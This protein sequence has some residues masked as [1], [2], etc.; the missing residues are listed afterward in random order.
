MNVGDREIE[1]ERLES[2]DEPLVDGSLPLNHRG[3]VGE[4]KLKDN[5]LGVVR[6]LSVGVS[7]ADRT[8]DSLHKVEIALAMSVK[9]KLGHGSPRKW[10]CSSVGRTG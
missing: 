4:G 7:C 10:K 9:N 5:V 3:W 8:E 6:D 2:I 1:F